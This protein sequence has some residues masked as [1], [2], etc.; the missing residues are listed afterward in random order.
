MAVVN[1]FNIRW[2]I[3]RVEARSLPTVTEKIDHVL[4]YLKAYPNIHNWHRV[5]N[6]TKTSCMSANWLSKQEYESFSLW[7]IRNKPRFMDSEDNSNS[8]T[9]IA[10]DEL[11]AVLV[12]LNKRN[13]GFQ[14]NG[15]TPKAHIEFVKKL[16]AEL[17]RRKACEYLPQ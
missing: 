16:E 3:T 7:L 2:Q 8:L 14:F 10:T 9:P 13:Y 5:M 11:L 4:G 12:D 1:K 17:E 6:W 15:H